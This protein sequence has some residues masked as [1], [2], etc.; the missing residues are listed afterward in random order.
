MIVQKPKGILQ[1]TM[2]ILQ[3]RQAAGDGLKLALEFL[4]TVM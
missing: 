1:E 2:E 3:A 4:Y